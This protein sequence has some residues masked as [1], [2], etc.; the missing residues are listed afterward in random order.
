VD[1][2]ARLLTETGDREA[3]S[4]RAVALAVGVTPPSIYLHFEDKQALLLAVC[5]RAFAHL[6]AVVE[7][8][9]AGAPDPLTELIERGRA[10]ARFG[11]EHPE[12]YR[13]LFMGRPEDVPQDKGV[14]EMLAEGAFARLYDNVTRGMASGV[15]RSADP[16][17]VATGLWATVHGATSLAIAH[18]GHVPVPVDE[19]IEHVL[20]VARLGLAP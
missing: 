7:A 11:L 6:D 8:A 12:E 2:T 17:L 10:Y 4:I 18:A 3:V 14:A 13:I 19:L 16:V 20:E 1:A 9:V 15:M 5:E